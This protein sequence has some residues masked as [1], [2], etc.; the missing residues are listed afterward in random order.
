MRVVFNDRMFKKD[1][2][3]LIN[4]SMGYLDG[5]EKGKKE[6]LDNLGS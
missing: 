2:K 4:Y 5:I 3:N 1:M 6:F